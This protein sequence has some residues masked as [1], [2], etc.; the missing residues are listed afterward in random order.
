MHLQR[1]W[2]VYGSSFFGGFVWTSNDTKFGCQLWS[3]IKAYQSIF[4]VFSFSFDYFSKPIFLLK[5]LCNDVYY[6]SCLLVIKAL[7]DE[8]QLH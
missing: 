3:L 2:F 6:K 5:I 4:L 1:M 8:P 7:G